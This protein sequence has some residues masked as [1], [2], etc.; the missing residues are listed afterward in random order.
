[1]SAHPCRCT[2]EDVHFDCM[3]ARLE[4]GLKKAVRP[5]GSWLSIWS[6]EAPQPLSGWPRR[7]DVQVKRETCRS[8]RAFY[9]ECVR[10]NPR[11]L[12]WRVPDLLGVWCLR[13][14]EV[15]P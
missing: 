10:E 1:M 3:K 7:R 15:Q 14:G 8:T 11:K 5:V 9:G 2:A 4:P 13:E 6:E 12:E